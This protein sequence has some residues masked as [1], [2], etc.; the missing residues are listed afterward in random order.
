[1][2]PEIKAYLD[3]S[4]GANSY[5]LSEDEVVMSLCSAY[6]STLDQYN[7]EVVVISSDIAKNEMI[8]CNNGIKTIIWDT[9]YWIYFTYY[10]LNLKSLNQ[11]VIHHSPYIELECDALWRDLFRIAFLRTSRKTLKHQLQFIKYYLSYGMRSYPYEENKEKVLIAQEKLIG[12][13]TAK[14]YAF[15]HEL[16]HITAEPNK[17]YYVRWLK[18]LFSE[19]LRNTLCESVVDIDAALNPTDREKFC[20]YLDRMRAEL[21]AGDLTGFQ[22]IIADMRAIH[23]VCTT[24][25]HNTS[26]CFGLEDFVKLKEGIVVQRSFSLRIRNLEAYLR[27]LVSATNLSTLQDNIMGSQFGRE[28]I[29]RDR[30]SEVTE[31]FILRDSFRQIEAGNDIV[32]DYLSEPVYSSKTAQIV[33]ESLAEHIGKLVN[34]ITQ[35]QLSPQIQTSNMS[36]IIDYLLFYPAEEDDKN[37][38][39]KPVSTFGWSGLF[40]EAVSIES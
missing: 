9:N 40:F 15:L 18:H 24:L 13:A 6:R 22:E 2:R 25:L 33:N 23:S 17:E 3:L 30:L 37:A 12:I 29:I 7:I 28:F 1:M 11:H 10:F 21:Y 8:T 39:N 20:S 26:D 16:A 27:E 32:N 34:R 5:Q 38:I 14:M 35:E 19:K 31:I 4:R 36:E